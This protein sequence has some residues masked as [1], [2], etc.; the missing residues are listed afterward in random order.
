MSLS[1]FLQY[2]FLAII[3]T[4]VGFSL[5]QWNASRASTQKTAPNNGLVGYWSFD[6]NTGTQAGDASGNN[7]TGTLTNGP[8]WTTGKLGQAINFDGVDDYVFVPS[9]SSVGPT[10]D[11]TITAWIK[12]T[13][14][15]TFRGILGKTDATNTNYPAPY[16][17]YL[18]ASNGIPVLYRGDGSVTAGHSGVFSATVAPATGKWQFVAVTMT[19]STVTHY[20]NGVQNGSG[21]LPNYGSFTITNGSGAARIG[22]RNDSVPLMKGGIDEARIYNR[23]LSGTE[24]TNLYNLGAEKLNVSPVSNLTSGLVGYWTFDGKDTPWSSSSAGTAT[25]RSGSSNTGTL[26]NMSRATSPAEGKL[27]Q[28]L[29]FD[30]VDDEITTA[31][32]KG[33]GSSL[34]IF[35][36]STWFKTSAISAR[37]IIGIEANQTGTGSAAFDRDIYV[38]TDGKVYF[39]V[40]D[41][42]SRYTTSAGALNDGNWHHAVG[43]SNG[44]N[45]TIQLYVDGVLQQTTAIGTVWSS[46][47]SSYW[48]I[49]GYKLTGLTNGGG[50]GYFA[51]SLDEV[52]IYNRALSAGEVQSLYD[53]GASDKVNTSVSQSQ[54]TGRLDSGLVG[55]WKL[56][57]ASGTTATDSSTN[58]NSGTLT[59]GPTWT[60]GQ[61]NSGIDFDGTDDHVTMGDATALKLTGAFTTSAWIYPQSFGGGSRGRIIDK[62]GGASSGYIFF[63]DNSNLTNGIEICVN[64]CNYPSTNARGVANAVTL[65]TWQHFVA[66]FDGTN[67]TLYKNGAS[68]GSQSLSA[69]NSGIANF[70]IGGKT[71]AND[72]NFDGY[73]DEVRVYKRALSADEV[74]QLYRLTAPTGVDTSLKGY[75]SFDG[76]ATNWTSSSA[77]TVS[78]LSGSGNT[79]TQTNMSQ[80]TSVIRGKLGQALDFDGTDDYT[81]TPDSSTLDITDSTNFT[82]T[83]WFNRDT[84]TTDDTIIGK[85]NGQASSDTGYNAYIDDST[86]KLTIVGNDGTDQYKMESVSTF[87]ATDWHHF[88]LVWDDSSSANTKLY[89]DGVSEAATT[90]G[91]FANVNSL[92]NAL[93]FRI[94]AESDNGNPF[95]GKIDEVRIYNRA[96]SATEVAALYN[97]GR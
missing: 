21:A 52:R 15:A 22:S 85:S 38:G 3:V 66:S 12:V 53:L 89:I 25:D 57:D 74:S 80:S 92:A 6:E 26:T 65:N 75:W 47:T 67:V 48:R 17:Y 72:R 10:G 60:T 23:A 71:S 84:F 76:S 68:L 24:I 36:L 88:A 11:M 56:D 62:L 7:N 70:A 55:Y 13:D 45:E 94:G 93:T 90:T 87:T 4:T 2:L 33:N 49:G 63:I 27:G 54:G 51:G 31:T 39:R 18:G 58:A 35:T 96:L 50:D 40:Y 86:D 82:L 1:R 78:D 59:N 43:V 77:G 46:Y 69:P 32:D 28:A 73:I 14:F 5:Y 41:G 64:N 16:D 20:L 30:G 44:D 83:G 81:T 61:I 97:S 8:T 34:K 9:S 29:T 79:G 42:V 19:G 91:T 37:K 95:D